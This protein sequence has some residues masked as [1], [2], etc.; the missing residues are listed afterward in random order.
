MNTRS[1][2]RCGHRKLWV[3]Q[4]TRRRCAACRYT[5]TPGARGLRVPRALARRIISEF[6]LEHSTNTILERVEVTKYTLLTLLTKL[7]AVMIRD[8]PPS[9]SGIVAVDETYV[10]GKWKNRRKKARRKA[11]KRG[12]GT[13]K[14]PVFG[15]LCRE[16]EVWAEVVTGVNA[17]DL[18]PIIERRVRQG[19]TVVSDEWKG[20]T[21]IAT[22]GYV[23]RLVDHGRGE[24]SD[25][26]GGHINGLEGFWGYV[27]RKLAA[28]GGIR[29]GRLPLYL[30]EYV[31]RYNHRHLSVQ[32]RVSR[33]LR[34]L[35]QGS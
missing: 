12:R 4:G 7:R 19:S 34:L 28:K 22:K 14:Q 32:E 20:Y 10:G 8:V 18:Q 30:G 15:I 21:G 29:R 35:F 6:A 31:W 23:H 27:K 11:A 33:L 26:K 2:P 13:P 24:Y 16:G 5:F 3:V 1:C 25:R 17:S 9:V